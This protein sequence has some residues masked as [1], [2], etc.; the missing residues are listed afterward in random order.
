MRLIEAFCL[1]KHCDKL[2]KV[3]EVLNRR[4]LD[5]RGGPRTP[6]SLYHDVAKKYNDKKWKPKSFQTN[7]FDPRSRESICLSFCGPELTGERVNVLWS[8]CKGDFKKGEN[9]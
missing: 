7:G 9:R 5:A 8:I 3:N 6:T 1:P 4:Q 2:L